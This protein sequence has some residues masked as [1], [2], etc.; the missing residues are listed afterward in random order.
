MHFKLKSRQVLYNS[1]FTFEYS[2]GPKPLALSSSSSLI[3]LTP[4]AFACFRI[5]TKVLKRYVNVFYAL[6]DEE[7]IFL[8]VQNFV[9]IKLQKNS[10]D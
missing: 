5:N 1:T 6:S 4:Y 3:F 10:L 7:Y 2:T 9:D 8:N